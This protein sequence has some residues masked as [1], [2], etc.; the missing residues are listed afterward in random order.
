MIA[1]CSVVSCNDGFL[2]L[3]S[4]ATLA[5]KDEAVKL[6]RQLK[7]LQYQFD[8]LTAQ[9]STLVQGRRARVAATSTVSG[10]LTTLDD[11]LSARNLQVLESNEASQWFLSPTLTFLFLLFSFLLSISFNI[12]GRGFLSWYM[13]NGALFYYWIKMFTKSIC[14]LNTLKFLFNY[15]IV[16]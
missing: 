8:M 5:Y 11:S 16:I 13:L 12:V 9:A 10:H 15:F 6:Q 3:F 1:L 4:E 2:F 7:H 14:C